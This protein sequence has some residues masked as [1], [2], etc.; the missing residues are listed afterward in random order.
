MF[1][2]AKKSSST[3]SSTAAAN[4]QRKR[5]ESD[6]GSA[7][8]S[9]LNPPVVTSGWLGRAANSS[10]AAV[11]Q[12]KL[13][14]GRAGD[15][16]EKEADGMADKV[17]TMPEPSTAA[18]ERKEPA[19]QPQS[20]M[21]TISRMVQTAGEEERLQPQAAEEEEEL[22]QKQAAE[23]EELQMQ[24]EER[25]PEL[26]AQ[27]EEE[28]EIQAQLAEKELQAQAEEEEK[29]QA[30]PEE[31]EEIQPKR[32]ADT[33]SE[34]GHGF[35]STLSGTKGSG[36]P[37]PDNV[38]SYMEPRFG[39]DFSNVR[40]HTGSDATGMSS[41]IRAQAFTHGSDIYFNRGKFNPG[42]SQGKHLIAHELTHTIQQGAVVQKKSAVRGST[43]TNRVQRAWYNDA[44][45][46]V[47]GA[48]SGA[49]EWVGDSLEAGKDWLMGKIKGLIQEVP[50]YKLFTVVLGEDP[51][52]NKNVDRSG[53]NFI[54]AGLDIIPNGKKY[55]DKLKKEGALE[56]AAG[57]LDDQIK[58]L[59]GV[60]L[61]QVAK[62]FSR[63]WS[64][65]S[66][67]DVRHPK[68]VMQDLL[69]VFSKPM[70]KVISFAK[71]VASKF[72][73]IVKDYLLSKVV[74][75]IKKQ[76][77]PTPYPLLTVILGEDP[78][79]GETV[80]PTGKNILTGFIKLHPDGDQQL[81]QMKKNKTFD[82]TAEWVTGAIK[83]LKTIASGLG[84]AF[85]TVWDKVTDINTLLNPI[86]T[87]KQIF[88]KFKKPLV[89]LA[90]FVWEVG[91]KILSFIKDAL[92]N[93][94]SNFA[95]NTRGYPLITV[96]LGRDPFTGK[97]V[98]R[99]VENII[100]GFFSLM[101]GGEEKFKKLKE[102]GAIAQTTAWMNNAIE[103]LGITWEYI[104]GLFITAWKSLS[105]HD[106]AKPFKAFQRIVN[107]FKP[108][109]KRLF[110]FVVKVVK[111]VLEIVLK[112]MNF[113]SD[114]I[115]SIFQKT[116]AVIQHIKK[117]PIGF[118]KNLLKGVKQGFKQFFANIGKHL[119]GGLT[120]WL[121]GTLEEAGIKPPPDLSLKSI[122]GL[123]LQIMGVTRDRI[124]DKIAKKIG[125]EK[126][127]KIRGFMDRL[128]GIW[129]FV[130]DVVQ[131]GPIAI[132]EYVKERISNIWNMILEQV[133][134][135]IMEKII[136]KVTT[137]LLSMLDPTGVMAVINSFIAIYNAIESFI[138]YFTKML[139]MVNRF[140]DGVAAVARGN[141]APAANKLEQS[142]AKG[143]PIAIGFLANQ[144]GLSGLGKKIGKMIEAVRKKVDKA[145]DW[146]IDKAFK[147]GGAVLSFGRAAAGK[148][149]SWWKSRKKFRSDDGA[150]HSL[151]F[152]GKG[153]NAK[154][155]I[156]SDPTNYKQFIDQ[157]KPVNDEQKN[158]KSEARKIAVQ[159]DN[160]RNKVSTD[161][162]GVKSQSKD[163][164]ELLDEL[165]K[166]TAVLSTG[167]GG[168]LPVSTK[169]VY[170]GLSS[171][172]FA[173]S[174]KIEKLTRLGPPGSKP[175]VSNPVWERLN[176]RRS[177][178]GSYYI[179]G[180]LLNQKLH[181]SGT[182]WKNITPLSRSG[183][184]KHETDVESKVKS[185][186]DKGKVVSY[187]VKVTYGRTTGPLKEI[188]SS[189]DPRKANKV[190]VAEA[191]KYVPQSI[192][193]SAEEV[194]PKSGEPLKNSE[195]NDL[196]LVNKVVPNPVEQNSITDY[197][198]IGETVQQLKRLSINNPG[199][200][201]IDALIELHNIGTSRAESLMSNKPYRSW[202][203][204]AEKN[205]GITEELI[206]TWQE[207][208]NP[209]GDRLVYFHGQTEWK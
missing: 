138:E 90:D 116:A 101:E 108:P 134:S 88:K 142:L 26:Q 131:R 24:P 128:T 48:V 179:L 91:G 6:N 76:Q 86:D 199:T 146:L 118:I 79:T 177:G 115:V 123:V 190:K 168:S 69:K 54:E 57:W 102:S 129:T 180:H 181:G 32:T 153:K 194:D 198:V 36:D 125:R 38:R 130:K 113:P 183:N 41:Q 47:S 196:P 96:I 20:L 166:H 50:G 75:F 112:I 74:D 170:G 11:V 111:K 46:A 49:A 59:E 171:A 159:I 133:K 45:G 7:R 139:Q 120:D 97:K 13:S 135:W 143:V 12:P 145:I 161:P 85:S 95:R 124:F 19:V 149:R 8:G 30:Q 43:G 89:E 93:R 169:P 9:R 83:R 71:S 126:M 22:V 52:T 163:F 51:I 156:A 29:I 64:G 185:A 37:L 188:T 103:Q 144:V 205:P 148:I 17:L 201:A 18:E 16:F 66:L 70:N 175:K 53:R 119:M 60:S 162:A 27:E 136:K 182:T 127:Q 82:K 105:I 141:I 63:F 55:R 94:L 104:K 72:L 35:E 33:G 99:S 40:I 2:A 172:G 110:N 160:L 34:V 4:I 152:K 39:A 140:V 25:E 191:E 78:I 67:T 165:A 187:D 200:K 44:W 204:V 207:Q 10:S 176:L 178:K 77:S 158:A 81:K 151:Y 164:S 31:R 117:D 14:V 100:K 209:D 1:S 195:S 5:A 186:V 192:T 154:L 28:E 122:L 132:W 84:E 167:E 193:C 65:L 114:L 173:T 121:F 23:E 15:K 98:K 3:D 61:K 147:A 106:I 58:T 174:M 203:E 206:E 197:Q 137:K 87:F 56:E 62:D 189:N 73:E 109:I 208:T 42:T 107:L 202:D 21:Q 92:L 150:E 80:E 155:M 157:I 184:A 68:K